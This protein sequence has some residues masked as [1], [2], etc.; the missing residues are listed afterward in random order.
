MFNRLYR[1]A[2]VM[3]DNRRE[4]NSDDEHYIWEDVMMLLAR[5]KD[6]FWELFN[7]P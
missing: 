4:D 5:D 3:F 2:K 6:K 1:T 7:K